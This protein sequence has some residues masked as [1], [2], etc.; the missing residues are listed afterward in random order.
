MFGKERREGVLEKENMG[1]VEG[2]REGDKIDGES[3]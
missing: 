1:C 3:I 2:E